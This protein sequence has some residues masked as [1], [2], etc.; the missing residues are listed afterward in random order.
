MVS[1]V[2]EISKIFL[3]AFSRM[4]IS[5]FCVPFFFSLLFSKLHFCD[6]LL[7]E[8]EGK[9]I[10]WRKKI[11]DQC[12]KGHFLILGIFSIENFIDVNVGSYAVIT[13]NM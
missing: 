7:Q 6:G 9:Q 1:C 10:I 12:L 5:F 13:N 8:R 4:F 2:L 3:N 11:K